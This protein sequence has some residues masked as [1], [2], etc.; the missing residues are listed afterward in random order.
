MDSEAFEF[1]RPGLVPGRHPGLTPEAA[2][3]ALAPAEMA[4][5]LETLDGRMPR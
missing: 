4:L 1:D 3:R 5:L 2:D